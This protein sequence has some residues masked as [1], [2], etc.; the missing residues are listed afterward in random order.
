[1]TTQQN[2]G[3]LGN[4]EVIGQAGGPFTVLF[5]N[6]LSST[7]VGAIGGTATGTALP[8]FSSLNGGTILPATLN[9]VAN[10]NPNIAR[11]T[12]GQFQ[13]YLNRIPGLAGNVQVFGPNGG[14]FQADYFLVC[15][16]NRRR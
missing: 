12:A 11:P 9:G 10:A 6:N 14:P 16:R 1:M 8:T 3:L 5:K 4:I 13:T 2:T 7:D 15:S